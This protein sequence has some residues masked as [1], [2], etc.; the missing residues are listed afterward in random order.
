MFK[1]YRGRLIPH[2]LSGPVLIDSLGLPRFW[3]TVWSL[4]NS[5]DLAN[6]SKVKQFRYLEAF[7]E[8]SDQLKGSGSLDD[9]IASINIELLGEILEAYFIAIQNQSSVN[10]SSEH[11][12]QAAFQFVRDIVLRLSKSDL[13][14]KKIHMIEARLNKLNMLYQQLRISKQRNSEI[15][16]SLPATVIEALYQLL[17]PDSNSNP[18]K[19]F[20]AKWRVFIIFVLLLHQGLRRGELLLLP[21]DAVK[22]GF[23]SKLGK[24]Q[25]WM[26]I[27]D[28]HYENDDPRYSKP[29]IKTSSSIRQVPVSELTTNIIQE[30]AENYRGRPDHSFLINSQHKKPLSTEAITVLFKKISNALPKAAMI[31]LEQRTGKKSITPHDLRHT[32]AVARL[33]QLLS[34]GDSMD[35]VLA[36]R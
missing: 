4:F 33:N 32:C 28:N 3:I 24:T 14:L 6:S 1:N 27:I 29:S 23:D 34:K 7:Y 17:D 25:Y 16:R 10:K 22:S 15:I 20:A 11:K 36:L 19:T 31:E 18:F 5:S 9:A 26:S 12:W 13:P 21:A 8:F 30:Y 35:E 2:T